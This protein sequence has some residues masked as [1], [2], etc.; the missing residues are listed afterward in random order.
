MTQHIMTNGNQVNG[1][2]GTVEMTDAQV[3]TVVAGP[4]LCTDLRHRVDVCRLDVCGLDGRHEAYRQPGKRL[5]KPTQVTKRLLPFLASQTCLKEQEP[6]GKSPAG[7][8]RDA[9]ELPAAAWASFVI[10]RSISY[11][12]VSL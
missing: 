1:T 9:G 6:L 8:S 3:S 7:V 4:V 2:T 5:P 12:S 11:G 10:S